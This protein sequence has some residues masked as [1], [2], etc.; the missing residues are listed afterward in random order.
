MH[1][2]ADRSQNCLISTATSHAHPRF[3]L[4]EGA[5][6]ASLRGAATST[7][8]RR[9]RFTAG[10]LAATGLTGMFN[11]ATFGLR[12]ILLAILKLLPRWSCMLVACSSAARDNYD[13]RRGH[14]VRQ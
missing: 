10:R 11:P 5:R 6:L 1:V 12:E 3:M 9:C 7:D 2:G 8:T 4:S 14:R 13:G